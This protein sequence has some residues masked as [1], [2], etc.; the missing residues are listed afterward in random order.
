MVVPGK[1]FN[2]KE[3]EPKPMHPKDSKPPREYSGARKDFMVWHENFSST[4]RL[5]SSK[6]G[7]IIEWLRSRREKGFSDGQAKADYLAYASAHD[8]ED[9]YL[10]ENFNVFQGHL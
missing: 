3:D 1:E 5:G 9:K 10:E 4:L 8:A 6:W 2:S 7:K